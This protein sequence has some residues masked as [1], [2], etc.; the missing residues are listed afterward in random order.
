MSRF[1]TELRNFYQINGIMMKLKAMELRGLGKL[2]L[3][4]HKRTQ[5]SQKS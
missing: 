4:S 2:G 3:F 5:R 1:L